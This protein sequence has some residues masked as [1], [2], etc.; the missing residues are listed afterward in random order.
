MAADLRQLSLYIRSEVVYWRVVF[1]SIIS[2][3]SE[4]EAAPR[5]DFPVILFLSYFIPGVWCEVLSPQNVSLQTLNTNYLLRWD[6]NGNQT[7]NVTFTAEH[8][9]K[10][11]VLRGKQKKWNL[12]CV[13]V[14]KHQCDFTAGNLHYLGIHVLRVR[15]NIH[16]PRGTL[17]SSWVSLDFCPDKDASLG[18][19]SRVEL[20]LHGQGMLDIMIFDPLSH[21][22]L[23]MK[24]NIQ[25]MYYRIVYWNQDS[26]AL[27]SINSSRN[28]VT[29]SNLDWW[30]WYCVKVQSRYDYYNKASPYSP[31]QCQR[32]EGRTS[33][34]QIILY[35][36]LSLVLC[37]LLVFLF[38]WSLLHGAKTLKSTLFPSIHLPAHIQEYL[39]SS[40]SSDMP[41]LLI[42]DS[43]T[44]IFTDRL[45]IVAADV[46]VETHSLPESSVCV[47]LWDPGRISHHGSG[48]SGVYSTEE[49]SGLVP[50]ATPPAII[51]SSDSFLNHA[52]S[53]TEQLMLT[54]VDSILKKKEEEDEESACI[55]AY[56]CT[57]K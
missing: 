21:T 46:V 14:H 19:P 35:F 15:A 38:S 18:P 57:V 17:H 7:E 30:V 10:F 23:S 3:R 32:V 48:D 25:N 28:F 34:F 55:C 5:M 36:T 53:S 54:E 33:Y 40:S 37:F 16:R 24:E 26:H 50:R 45:S 41:H 6:W 44:E 11:R 22:N 13:E 51:D 31:T 4:M 8:L 52:M 9:G 12:M 42:P 20:S 43:E 47:Q 2:L 29:L 56:D 1:P 39:Q 27:A 49:G